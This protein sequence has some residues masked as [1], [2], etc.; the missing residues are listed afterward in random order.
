MSQPTALPYG[1][2]D[3]KLTKYTDSSGTLLGTVSVDL[4]NMNTLSF[5]ETEEFSELR[6]DDKLI[7]TRGKGSQVEW[8]LEAGGMNFAAWAIMTG[9]A[10]TLTGTTPNR[11]TTFRKRSTDQRPY[12]RIDGQSISDSGGDITARIY[13]ARVNDK[14]EG[15]FADGEFFMTSASGLGLPLLGDYDLLYDFIQRETS[16]PITTTAIPSP[17]APPSDVAGSPTSA[18][19]ATITWTT[20]PNATGYVVEQSTDGLTA[21]ANATGG[22][23]AT[24]VGTASITGLV[25]ATTKFFRVKSTGPGGPSDPSAI[26]SITQP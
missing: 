3:L 17:L 14:V 23:I 24:N 11:V 7:A 4:P 10:V 21:W 9:G 20:V 19:A 15:E 8:S 5:S 6:G 25:T 13:R 1:I 12:F 2:R 26:I 18:T 22:T 16:A